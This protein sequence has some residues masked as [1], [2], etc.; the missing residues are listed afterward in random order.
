MHL[1]I[2]Y[3]I[4]ND[5]RRTKIHDM[6]KNYGERIQYSVFECNLSRKEYQELRR[7][8]EPLI[9]VEETDSIR[10]YRLCGECRKKAEHIGGRTARENVAI[11]L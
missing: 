8:L 1:V 3:D 2:S 4:Q 5:R 9:D 7:K 10:F 6:L 11:I